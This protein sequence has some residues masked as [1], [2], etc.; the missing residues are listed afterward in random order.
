[1]YSH[2]T[3]ARVVMAVVGLGIVDIPTLTAP[4]LQSV[5]GLSIFVAGLAVF[6][7]LVAVVAL[8]GYMYYVRAFGNVNPP[9]AQPVWLRNFDGGQTAEFDADG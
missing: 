1:M 8:A 5:V 4:D 7:F 3:N 6:V 9:E 2:A